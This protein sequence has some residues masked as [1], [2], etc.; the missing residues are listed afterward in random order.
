MYCVQRFLPS[1]LFRIFMLDM[2][3]CVQSRQ[4]GKF[5][6]AHMALMQEGSWKVGSFNVDPH[7]DFSPAGFSTD[8]ASVGICW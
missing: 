1:A 7:I 5:D 2:H 3:V 8:T 6:M 4:G